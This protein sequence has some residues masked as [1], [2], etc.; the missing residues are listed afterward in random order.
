[1][2][3]MNISFFS[4]P[5]PFTIRISRDVNIFPVPITPFFPSPPCALVIIRLVPRI[6]RS[7]EINCTL[8]IFY[9]HVQILFNVAW[10]YIVII[11]II[12]TLYV[13][14]INTLYVLHIVLALHAL[15][16]Q[17]VPFKRLLLIIIYV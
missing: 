10:L 17:L 11:F 9:T 4:V 15:Y 16:I 2:L 3:I 1:M 8:Y 14:H 7:I 5:G 13:L 12:N 6:C